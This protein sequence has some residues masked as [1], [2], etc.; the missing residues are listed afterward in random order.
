MFSFADIRDIFKKILVNI[1]IIN[2]FIQLA[3]SQN[4]INID[5]EKSSDL[6]YFDQTTNYHFDKPYVD[7]SGSAL[8]LGPISPSQPSIMEASICQGVGTIKFNWCKQSSVADLNFYIDN[9]LVDYCS[10][11]GTNGMSP[12]GPHQIDSKKNHKLK[13]SYAF[14]NIAE[15]NPVNSQ[16]WIDD[17]Q[18]ENAVFCD[19]TTHKSS[20]SP[21][22]NLSEICSI[23]NNTPEKIY[24]SQDCNLQLILNAT[25]IIEKFNPKFNKTFIL[26]GH[27]YKGNIVIHA[28]DIRIVSR[29]GDEIN[30]I[31]SKLDGSYG[32]YNILIENTS[33][34]SI[35]GLELTTSLKG[36]Q[37]ENSTDCEVK[38]N[39]IRVLDKNSDCSV[40][41]LMWNCSRCTI[42]NNILH[43][44][45]SS[46]CLSSKGM[47]LIS[48]SGNVFKDNYQENFN[49][50]YC[51]QNIDCTKERNKIYDCG[52]L[53]CQQRV[54]DEGDCTDWWIN[55]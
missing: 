54:L 32:D 36:V 16:A 20:I 53:E 31:R 24:V 19:Y 7:Y 45:D 27:N 11:T 12:S 17:I 6:L 37:I 4:I 48:S 13:W 49:Y 34:V 44:S 28:K 46:A 47:W 39:L 38:N 35:I 40:G 22:N 50:I 43:G 3:V 14:N 25:E 18:L 51:L 2:I 41:L 30:T 42:S 55:E 29:L 52:N 10:R 5:F 8:E 23:L 33:N 1:I 9:V 26:N 21:D 15:R